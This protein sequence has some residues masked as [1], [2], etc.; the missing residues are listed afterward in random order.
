MFITTK[1]WH[2]NYSDPEGALRPSL[3]KLRL[4]YVDMYL[5]HW[6]LNGVAE[7]K[8]PRLKLWAQLE[9]FVGQGLTK[10]IAT[11]SSWLTC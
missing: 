2:D 6:P 1:L 9:D 4:D 3:K 8:V 10:S 11:S 5:V 7:H